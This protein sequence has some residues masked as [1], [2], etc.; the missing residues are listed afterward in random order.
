MNELLD[1]ALGLGLV[2]LAVSMLVTAMQEVLATVFRVRARTL[3]QG[4]AKFLDDPTG[5]A[6]SVLTEL[7][8]QPI[9]ESLKTVQKLPHV[10]N[11]PSYISAQN[12][13]TA[14]LA[15]ATTASKLQPTAVKAGDVLNAVESWADARRATTPFAEGVYQLVAQAGGDVSTLKTSLETWYD[16]TMDRISGAYKRWS[17]VISFL[18][19]LALAIV[20]NVDALRIFGA[21]LKYATLRTEIA[22]SA[23][24]GRA[25]ERQGRRRHEGHQRPD[26]LARDAVR[27]PRPAGLDRRLP[28][29]RH[30][31]D[32]G[33]ALLVRPDDPDREHPRRRSEAREEQR[34]RRRLRSPRR[35]A[36]RRTHGVTAWFETRR[37]RAAPHHDERWSIH[38]IRHPEERPKAASRRTHSAKAG[39]IS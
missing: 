20:L 29:H 39:Q 4:L 9:I 23:D 8:N 37:R 2:F 36:S 30:R 7:K 33:R 35:R 10:T 1:L 24:L 25:L 38:S 32:P 17:Q 22:A 21:L 11:F 12:F 13:S 34:Q 19:G 5:V 31:R 15:A 26:R 27:S 3:E 14:V 28:D 18:I 6:K 16:T